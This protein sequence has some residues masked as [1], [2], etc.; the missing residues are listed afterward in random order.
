MGKSDAAAALLLELLMHHLG[1]LGKRGV[2]PGVLMEALHLVRKEILP[3]QRNFL[4]V[5]ATACS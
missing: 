4:L 1:V 3:G 2:I 5:V